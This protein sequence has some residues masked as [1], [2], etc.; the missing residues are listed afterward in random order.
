MNSKRSLATLIVILL[1]VAIVGYFALNGFTVGKYI[2]SPLPKAIKQGLDLTGGVSAVYQASDLDDPNLEENL[3]SAVAVFRT[4]LDAEGFTEATISQSGER[5][6]IEIPVNETNNIQDPNE[7]TAYLTAT[8]RVMFVAPTGSLIFE[9]KDMEEVEAVYNNSTGEYNVRFKLYPEA[10][11]AFA[12]ATTKFVGQTI[13]IFLDETMISRPTVESTIAGGEGYITGNFTAESAQQL[14]NQIRSGVMPLELD[15]IEVRSIS[16]TLGDQ[17]LERGVL[18]GI[19]GI[20]LVMLFMLLAYRMC[21]LVADIA[22]VIYLILVFFAMATIESVQLTLPGIAG[23]ILAVGMAVD[24]NVIIFERI[25]EELQNGKSM[26]TAAQAGFNRAFSAILDS[27][28]TTIIA[29]IV[30]LILGTGSIKGFAYTLLIGIVA[31]F[32]TAVLI[33]RGLFKLFIN[34]NS[35]PKLYSRSS[36]KRGAE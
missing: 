13:S 35:N 31:S 26:R 5:I 34:I 7:I 23:I 6:R 24:A 3:A 2:I 10:A 25:N 19:I 12:E 17:A 20:A 14:A 29:A 21:G 16:A 30:L 9:G 33:T 22:L 1:V 18:A 27:N 4:R 36:K 8:A 11:N 32:F 28:I 15:E